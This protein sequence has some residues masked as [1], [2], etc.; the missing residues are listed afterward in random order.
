MSPATLCVVEWSHNQR[1]FHIETVTD[2]LQMNLRA[3]HEQRPLDY[4]PLGI[5]DSKEEAEAACDAFHKWREEHRDDA[6][7]AKPTVIFR[8]HGEPLHL[9]SPGAE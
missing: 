9:T 1:C 5:Y 2:A 7:S 3:F 4:I 6:H 8:K